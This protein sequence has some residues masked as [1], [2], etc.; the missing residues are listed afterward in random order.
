MFNFAELNSLVNNQPAKNNK[1][2]DSKNSIDILSMT[3]LLEDMKTISKESEKINDANLEDL[4][5]DESIEKSKIV[6]KDNVQKSNDISTKEQSKDINLENKSTNAI[7]VELIET[8]INESKD[9]SIEKSL[10]NLENSSNVVLKEQSKDEIENQKT[11]QLIDLDIDIKQSKDNDFKTS[12]ANLLGFDIEKPIKNDIESQTEEQSDEIIRY[13][14]NDFQADFQADFQ[15]TEIN[16][17]YEHLDMSPDVEKETVLIEAHKY[18]ITVTNDLIRF[19][20]SINKMLK[21]L[22]D[23]SNNEIKSLRDELKT[24][25]D[26]LKTVKDELKTVKSDNKA[27]KK[28]N[29]ELISKKIDNIV[30]EYL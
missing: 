10:I 17:A 29:D 24:V 21:K 8:S 20:N 2:N 22:I 9:E 26:E 3:K 12:I 1:T 7:K 30:A 5:K 13:N 11:E 14:R 25:K 18:N 4:I 16:E 27:L 19:L 6:I 28:A 23:N 15:D